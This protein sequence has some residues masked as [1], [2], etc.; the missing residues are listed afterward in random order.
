MI[1]KLVFVILM[2]L[3]AFGE[4]YTP[5][6]DKYLLQALVPFL[7]PLNGL[8]FDGPA[9]ISSASTTASQHNLPNLEQMMYYNY[10]CASMYYGY[11]HAD[12][13]CEYCLKYKPDVFKHEGNRSII[14]GIAINLKFKFKYLICNSSRVFIDRFFSVINNKDQ[15]TLALVTLSKKRNEI[16]VAF[17]GTLNVFNI[18][19]DAIFISARNSNTPDQIKVHQGFYLATMSLYEAVSFHL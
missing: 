2:A 12:L 10:Y 11:G 4:E 18:L 1:L 16:V 14:I 3:G 19:Q 15:N 6:T 17:R 5:G 13:S 9:N 7:N 8:L